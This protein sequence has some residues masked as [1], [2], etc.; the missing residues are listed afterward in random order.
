MF[1]AENMEHRP[2]AGFLT[3]SGAPARPSSS[4]SARP[5]ADAGVVKPS[6]A[7]ILIVEDQEDVRRM[8]VTALTIEG[9][10]VDEAANGPE[11]LERLKQGRYQLVL[12]DYAMPGQTGSWMLREATRL[13]LLDHT[14]AVII[15]AHPD[16]EPV[17]GVVVISKPLDL[18]DFLEQLRKLLDPVRDPECPPVQEAQGHRVELVLYVS[19]A[20]SASRLAR[21]AVERVL[22][23]F[24]AS[25]VRYSVHDLVQE[26]DAGAADRVTFT[27]TLVRRYPAPRVWLLGGIRDP[28]IVSDLLR[29]CGVDSRG[30]TRT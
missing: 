6:T 8:M 16:I 3:R 18:D 9:H 12:S 20:S 28:L 23:E 29:A 11:G 13:G 5:P 25:Q 21:R 2:H 22:A 30:I 1:R 26:P 7:S 15:T 19:S 4:S 14:A 24:D 27:P 10:Q 17:P